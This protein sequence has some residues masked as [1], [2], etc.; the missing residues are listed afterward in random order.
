MNLSEALAM[1]G[2]LTIQQRNAAHEL[3]A[4]I[5]AD[6]AIVSSGRDLVAR[7]FINEQIDPISHLAVGSDA[8]PVDPD[9]D[10]RLGKELFRKAIAAEG[11]ERKLLPIKDPATNQE[12]LHAQIKLTVELDYHEG[13]GEL[14]EAG[15]FNA[16]AANADS[17]VMYNRVVF[18][19]ITKTPDFQL[20][21]IWEILF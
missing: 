9:K 10:T 20:T 15:L 4:E 7:L 16:D 19:V 2:R 6:N 21:L 8:T 13:N 18:P 1:Q 5:H 14:R 11:I 3:V 17:S 12:R